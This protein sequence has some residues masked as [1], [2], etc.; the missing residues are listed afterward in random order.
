[1]FHN[2]SPIVQ[3]LDVTN[4]T[5]LSALEASLGDVQILANSAGVV[6]NVAALDQTEEN[7]SREELKR[8]P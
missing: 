3:V 2:L 1:L 8:Q 5:S 7:W 4:S 6:P